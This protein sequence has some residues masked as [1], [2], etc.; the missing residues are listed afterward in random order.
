MKF[1]LLTVYC[2]CM[3]A[4]HTQKPNQ[5]QYGNANPLNHQIWT[6]LLQKHVSNKG[7]VNYK[8]F[9]ADK[10][11]LQQYLDQLTQNKPT[12]NW[13]KNAQLAYWINVYNA[14]TVKLIVDNYPVASIKDIKKGTM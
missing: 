4:C 5:V 11:L 8:G 6:D 2:L 9:V 3:L 14:F 10:A 13:S 12:D 1:G 7:N